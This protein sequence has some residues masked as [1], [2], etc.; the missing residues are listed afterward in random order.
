MYCTEPPSQR[1]KFLIKDRY[2]YRSYIAIPNPHC[3]NQLSCSARRSGC[4]ACP[5]SCQPFA[6]SDP[7]LDARPDALAATDPWPDA[8]AANMLSQTLWQPTCSARRSG[9]QHVQPDALAA[10]MFSQ[11]LWQPLSMA[12]HSGSQQAQPDAL[13]ATDARPDALAA[14]HATGGT[15]MLYRHAHGQLSAFC[16]QLPV[17]RSPALSTAHKARSRAPCLQTRSR[18][19]FGCRG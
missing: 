12:R 14:G 8:L 9:S 4:R 13:A 2:R 19:Q 3:R 11:T 7:F 10:N 16:R 1:S 17:L 18:I 6:D 15:Q 5:G